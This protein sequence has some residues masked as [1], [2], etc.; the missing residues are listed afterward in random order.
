MEFQQA[1]P[2]SVDVLDN[3]MTAGR[4]DSLL[5]AP[6]HILWELGEEV[7]RFADS[8][9]SIPLI[10]NE[11]P[12]Y[13]GGWP[14]ANFWLATNGPLITSA[15]LFP[16]QVLVKDPLIDWFSTDR[17][18]NEPLM[19]SRQGYLADD[20]S[21]DIRATRGFLSNLAPAL[22]RLKPLIDAGIIVLIPGE[23]AI[24]HNRHSIAQLQQDLLG[25]PDLAPLVVTDRFDPTDLA[26][27]DRI[28]GAFV[29]AAGGDREAQWGKAIERVLRYFSRE[30]ILAKS[31]HANYT[32]PWQFE[33]YVCERGLQKLLRRSEAQRIVQALWCSNL[34]LFSGLTPQLISEIHDDD[35]FAGFR[36]ELFD[37]Y[38]GLPTDA[39]PDEFARYVGEAESAKLTPRIKQAERLAKRGPLARMGVQLL[40]AAVHMSTAYLI[41]AAKNEV[42][43]STVMQGTASYL[44]GKLTGGNAT[45]SV[46]I[47]TRLSQHKRTVDSE[48][49]RLRY[50]VGEDADSESLVQGST[51]ERAWHI[52]DQPSMSVK[53][54]PGLIVFDDAFQ[55][56]MES[57][58]GGYSEGPYRPCPCGSGLKWRFCCRTVPRTHLGGQWPPAAP[59]VHPSPSS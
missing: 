2:T 22:L 31:Y 45:D 4:I 7:Q 20:G 16:G 51:R 42:G 53:T 11:H 46:R 28:R 27:D 25:A 17:Y 18:R 47:W 15:L 3:F 48:I 26:R 38:R 52:A 13:I 8:Y 5:H 32:A 24:Y 35:A 19:G 40:E 56:R 59:T 34:P 57:D 50:Q 54:T 30:Y 44:L 29:F 21:P 55:V 12:V 43:G 36:A 41:D 58:A 10:P 6:G 23:S 33:Q 9:N 1:Q 39:T 14:S 37:A 49:E